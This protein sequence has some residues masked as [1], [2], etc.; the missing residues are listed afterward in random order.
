VQGEKHWHELMARMQSSMAIAD[1]L[2]E[3]SKARSFQENDLVSVQRHL[4]VGTHHI[5][6]DSTGIVTIVR[7]GGRLF[8][9]K[10][11]CDPSIAITISKF[12]LLPA[13]S[14]AAV[15]LATN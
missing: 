14:E 4:L 6:K 2:P 8:D 10:F 3:R 7:D 5:F 1:K 15:Q 11:F 9:V 13:F 12:D